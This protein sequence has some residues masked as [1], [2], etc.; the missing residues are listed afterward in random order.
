MSE[1]ENRLVHLDVEVRSEELLAPV[2][3]CHKEPARERN[4]PIGIRELAEQHYEPLDIPRSM[5]VENT[6][7]RCELSTNYFKF[8]EPTSTTV[9][10]VSTGLFI[11]NL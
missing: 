10:V 6:A 2:L 9:G 11:E 1:S 5:R 7:V 3:L 8:K 4:T